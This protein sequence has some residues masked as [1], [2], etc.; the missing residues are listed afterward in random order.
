MLCFGV[1]LLPGFALSSVIVID[2]ED[3]G[4]TWSDGDSVKFVSG[5]MAGQSG[6]LMGYRGNSCG[7]YIGNSCG[8]YI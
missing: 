5:T 4:V 1:A 2:G 6:R 7:T 8:T 3:V